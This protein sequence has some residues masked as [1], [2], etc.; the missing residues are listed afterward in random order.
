[1]KVKEFTSRVINRARN[2]ILG[3]E[4][5]KTIIQFG[6]RGEKEHAEGESWKENGKTWIIKNG[7]PTS[8]SPL[9]IVKSLTTAP[10]FCPHCKKPMKQSR[11]SKTF[12]IRGRCMPCV[13]KEETDMKINGTF[14]QY[15]EVMNTKN[16]LAQLKEAKAEIK[17]FMEEEEKTI[18]SENGMVEEIEGSINKNAIIEDIEKT[19]KSVEDSL[20]RKE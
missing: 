9:D 5:D 17:Q 10:L 1:M 18:F 15:D 19:I 13:I 14:E 4:A 16:T 12:A 3:R 8:M 11:D 7:I 6:Y 20:L 2:I